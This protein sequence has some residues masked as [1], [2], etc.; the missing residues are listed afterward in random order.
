MLKLFLKKAVRDKTPIVGFV[1]FLLLYFNALLGVK[2]SIY[3]DNWNYS[4]IILNYLVDVP[5]LVFL[6]FVIVWGS[7]SINTESVTLLLS[8]PLSR[9]VYVLEKA[10][11]TFLYFLLLSLLMCPLTYISCFVFGVQPDFSLSFIFIFALMLFSMYSIGLLISTLFSS[12]KAPIV[13]FAV[14]L[15][16]LYSHY[17]FTHSIQREILGSYNITDYEL[18]QYMATN[19]QLYWNILDDIQALEVKE[20]WRQFFNPFEHFEILLTYLMSNGNQW[21]YYHSPELYSI[22]Q[23]PVEAWK[24]LGFL[25]FDALL[26]L[27]MASEVFHRKDLR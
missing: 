22:L 17:S 16:L 19:E 10:F 21:N 27:M 4:K 1:I 24:S 12:R 2:R 5:Y 9:R 18:S 6:I 15:L 26:S 11:S 23:M 14:F 8:K 7:R 3:F 13:A 25:A 20:S